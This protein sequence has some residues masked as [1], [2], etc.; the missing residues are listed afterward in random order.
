MRWCARERPLASLERLRR[1][2]DLNTCHTQRFTLA[3][4]DVQMFLRS[5]VNP[6]QVLHL[7]FPGVEDLGVRARSP[8]LRLA[9]AVHPLVREL[10]HP[11]REQRLEACEAHR[12][13]AA[14]VLVV[15]RAEVDSLMEQDDR[16]EGQDAPP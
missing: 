6:L 2:D 11:R 3:V 13:L 4:Y 9:P 10:L 5:P 1:Q 12:P 8:V 7:Y 14:V 16:I 15:G